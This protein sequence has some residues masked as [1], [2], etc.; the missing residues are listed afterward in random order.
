[1]PTEFEMRHK[2][3]KF[4]AAA[5]S[6]KK[7]TNP[8][9]QEQLSKRSPIPVWALGMILFVVIGGLVFELVRLIFL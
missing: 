3:Q 8:S 4:A 2:N 1:M 6:G 7:P 5:R 9:R